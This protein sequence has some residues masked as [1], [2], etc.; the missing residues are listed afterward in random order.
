MAPTGIRVVVIF[1]DLLLTLS[2]IVKLVYLY[3]VYVTD[4]IFEHCCLPLWSSAGETTV[5][6]VMVQ[7]LKTV[8]EIMVSSDP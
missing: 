8:Q 2:F 6:Y 5:W 7:Y 3:T 4:Y 1:L